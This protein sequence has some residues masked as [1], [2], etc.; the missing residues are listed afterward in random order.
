MLQAIQSPNTKILTA[1]QIKVIA[2]VCMTLDHLAAFGFELSIFERY[3]SILRTVGRVA[4]PLFLFV[5][6][7]KAFGIQ[8]ADGSYCCGSI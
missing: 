3:S 7:S 5:L 1:F 2:L 4:A 8:E 6:V